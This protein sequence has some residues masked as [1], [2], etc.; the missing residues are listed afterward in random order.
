[1]AQSGV[2]E[3]AV[4][5]RAARAQLV[6]SV[7]AVWEKAKNCLAIDVHDV[8]RLWS[9]ALFADQVSERVVNSMYAIGG[10]TSVYT[11]CLL[12]RAH[13]DLHV[14]MRHQ[15]AQPMWLEDAGRVVFGLAPNNPQY[16][17]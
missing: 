17:I 15:I 11:S 6:E 12:E 13:R 8:S 1:L 2:A 9:A 14:M 16:S 3:A 10:T 4:T 5:L 7:A